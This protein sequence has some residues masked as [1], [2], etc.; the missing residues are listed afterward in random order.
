MMTAKMTYR[1]HTYKTVQVE[2]IPEF[3]TDDTVLRAAMHVAGEDESSLFNWRVTRYAD[4]NTK[5]GVTLH[6]D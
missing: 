5:A 2:G 3:T 6:T 4:D 1:G